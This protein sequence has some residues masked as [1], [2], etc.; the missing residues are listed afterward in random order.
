[1]WLMGSTGVGPTWYGPWKVKSPFSTAVTQS[2]GFRLCVFSISAFAITMP[3]QKAWP[4]ES[5][6]GCA[7]FPY[8][9]T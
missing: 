2:S 9:A 6:T 7:L 8:L 5:G 4:H 3:L 1:M